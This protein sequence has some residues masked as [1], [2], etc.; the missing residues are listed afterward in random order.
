[1]SFESDPTIAVKSHISIP[2]DQFSGK[3]K[4]GA[5]IIFAGSKL[6]EIL[7]PKGEVKSFHTPVGGQLLEIHSSF[8]S[9][10]DL[11]TYNNMEYICIIVPNTAIPSIHGPKDYVA[12]CED[13]ERKRT[14]Q[15]CFS[16]QSTG[17][18]SRGDTCKFSHILSQ[19]IDSVNKENGASSMEPMDVLAASED[20]GNETAKRQRI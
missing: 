14:D 4:K 11:A 19:N 12:L 3:F 5:E 7:Q 2:T 9:T 1:M 18:C 10:I 6:F 20:N 13:I 17:K 15:S 16:F 8:Q